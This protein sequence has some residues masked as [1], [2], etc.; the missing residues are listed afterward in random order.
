MTEI[1]ESLIDMETKK[2]Q[3]G[4][5][6]RKCGI[7]VGF[8]SCS[9]LVTGLIIFNIKCGSFNSDVVVCELPK[10]CPI[11]NLCDGSDIL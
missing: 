8:L 7:C 3:G 1:K 11:K 2:K 10:Y 9:L 6:L 5:N 4:N